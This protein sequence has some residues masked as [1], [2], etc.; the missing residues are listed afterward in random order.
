MLKLKIYKAIGIIVLS[1]AVG[2]CGGNGGGADSSTFSSATSAENPQGAHSS[3][4]VA[5]SMVS[6]SGVHNSSL[7]STASSAAT[8][9]SQ[10][11]VMASSSSSPL[12]V[13]QP[14]TAAIAASRMG[15]GVNLGQ[16]F[17]NT[18]H[19][20]TFE[21]AKAKIDAYYNLGFRNIRIPITWTDPVGGSILVNDPQTGLLV[22]DH[23]RVA[24]IERVIDYALSL[25]DVYVVINAHH[26]RALKTFDR[27]QA[28][29]N[30]WGDLAARF[31]AKD[32]RLI[33]EI[34]NEPH[35]E[36]EAHSPMDPA[37]LRNMI[38]RAYA[39]IRTIDSQRILVFGGNQW[40]AYEEVPAVWGNLD[41]IGGGE[42]DYLM[43]TFH[44]YNPWSFNGDNQGDYADNWLDYDIH[45]PMDVMADWANTVGG[46]MPVY[47]GEWGVGWQSVLPTMNCNNIRL[48]YSRFHQQYAGPRGMPTALWDDGGWFG[49]FDH[50]SSEFGNNLAQCITGVCQW[51]GAE[52]FNDAC[53]L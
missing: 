29:E 46:G 23:A 35:L 42:D 2:A 19:P 10:S 34:L 30:L 53:S 33:Y 20:R 9:I 39:K 28:L 31:I 43:V 37:K 22:S 4:S 47:I 1:F 12:P 13:G 27:W 44:H 3:S 32:Y 16:M 51:D 40:F 14:I 21:T 15:M 49:V 5:S 7:Q 18:Q 26:E 52:R 24:V 48:W 36:D 6:S 45:H 8:S 17:E 25:P 41:L 38:G 11:S 50:A